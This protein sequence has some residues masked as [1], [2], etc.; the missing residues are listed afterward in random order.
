MATYPSNTVNFGSDVVDGTTTVIAAHVNTLRGEVVALESYLGVTPQ[1]SK[2]GGTLPTYNGS[3]TS[4][5]FGS[6]ADRVAN[7]EAGLTTALTNAT[8]ALAQGYVQLTTGTIAATT[9]TVSFGTVTGGYRKAVIVIGIGAV[10]G[11]TG[12]NVRPNS[13]ASGYR[14]SYLAHGATWQTSTSATSLPVT[15]AS[16]PNGS[17]EIIIEIIEPSLSGNK[18]VTWTGYNGFGNGNLVTTGLGTVIG[19]IDII[20]ATAYPTST[21]YTVYG[22]K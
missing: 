3:P 11:C 22:V 2:L 12:I 19:S 8:A 17:D 1:V 18:T 10:N 15:C 20:C 13:V 7:I 4:G 16:A 9:T 5:T 6:T 21:T 14:Y